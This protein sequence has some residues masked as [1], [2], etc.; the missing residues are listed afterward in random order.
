MFLIVKT[1]VQIKLIVILQTFKTKPKMGV[2][3]KGIGSIASAIYYFVYLIILLFFHV[4]QWLSFNLFGY[5]AHKFVVDYLSLCLMRNL[6]FVGTHVKFNNRYTIPTDK[7]IIIISN[8]QSTQDIAPLLWY[9][10]K[11]HPKC[12]AKKE[13]EKGIPS[14]SYNLRHG[15]S[16]LIDRNNPKQSITALKNFTQYIAK[17]NYAAIIFPEGTRSKNGHLKAFKENGLKILTKYMPNAV[18]VPVTINNSY[19]VYKYGKFPLHLGDKI[20]LT[21]HQPFKADKMPFKELIPQIEKT[22]K[23]G[24]I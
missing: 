10:R 7:P 20:T 18:I 1:I 8:H 21:V 22:I 23:S 13:L 3:E 5:K 16:V 11:N 14:I 12:V 2:L 6:W 15:G 17:N 4:L 9:F 24:L 19:K